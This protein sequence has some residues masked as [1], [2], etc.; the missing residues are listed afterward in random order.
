MG[1]DSIT[2]RIVRS[3]GRPSALTIELKVGRSQIRRPWK[4]GRC[5]ANKTV[6]VKALRQ[7][8]I[9]QPGNARS[10]RVQPDSPTA[11]LAV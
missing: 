5:S 1:D 3:E 7:I 4:P 6:D 10:S 11:K 9:L 2:W 8:E